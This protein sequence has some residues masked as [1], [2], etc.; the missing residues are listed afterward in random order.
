MGLKALQR[1]SVQFS[2]I[3]LDRLG[4]TL[5]LE[6]VVIPPE[7]EKIVDDRPADHFAGVNLLSHGDSGVGEQ[8]GSNAFYPRLSMVDRIGCRKGP[9]RF[10]QAI[11]KIGAYGPF[12]ET[13]H[14][15][16]VSANR[17]CIDC[18]KVLRTPVITHSEVQFAPIP[19]E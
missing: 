8:C 19:V 14:A 11:H 15:L 10:F 5:R 18:L 4:S 12:A 7:I 6:D 3:N 2:N 17:L 13:V 9:T 16:E 1:F